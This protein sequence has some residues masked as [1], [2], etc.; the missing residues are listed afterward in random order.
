MKYLI[1]I[2]SSKSKTQNFI[3]DSYIKAF[4]T[5]KTLPIIIPN[6]FQIKN[7]IITEKEIKSIQ[8]KAMNFAE[9]LDALILSGGIDINPVS[10]EKE[11]LNSDNFNIARD[12]LE[13]E[14]VKAF[15]A[16]KKPILGICRGFQL[17]GRIYKLKYWQENLK[18]TEEKHSSSL[19]NIERKEPLH[20]VHTFGEFAK[21]CKQDKIRTNSWHKQGFTFNE[22]GEK[23]STEKLLKFINKKPKHQN[24]NINIIMSTNCVIEG[25]ELTNLP[26][27]GVQ[28]HPEEYE[29]SI[30]IKYFINKY[31]E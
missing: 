11:N 4:T 14:L 18:I 15:I 2:T 24:K 10:F 30:I 13:A 1:G 29:K 17:L 28:N 12:I 31:L 8:R 26:I 23:F 16:K 6:F 20:Y 27:M 7:E 3:N 5:R 19:L 22:D 9:K 21:F 25:F